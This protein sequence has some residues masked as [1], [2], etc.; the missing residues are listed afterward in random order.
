VLETVLE[1]A[2]RSTE[3]Q[4][5]QGDQHVFRI[6]DQLGAEAPPT[7]GGT[8]RTRCRSGP[9]NS[10]MD[11]PTRIRPWHQRPTRNHPV[12]APDPATKPRVSIGWPPARPMESVRRAR[13]GAALSAVVTSPC[14]SVT[15][16]ARLSG[17]SSC[18]RAKLAAAGS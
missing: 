4:R 2:Y 10:T 16:P 8:T 3:P 9:S 7:S 14:D 11:C 5:Q 17:T 18:T 13:R 1:P 6:D 15:R 12:H